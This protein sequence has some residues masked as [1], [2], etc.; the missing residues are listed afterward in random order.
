MYR[1][2]TSHTRTCRSLLHACCSNSWCTADCYKSWPP[3][4]LVLWR[5]IQTTAKDEGA[6]TIGGDRACGPIQEGREQETNGGNRAC[7]P[8]HSWSPPSQSRTCTVAAIRSASKRDATTQ[9][10]RQRKTRALMRCT[11][12]PRTA[13]ERACCMKNPVIDFGARA[14]DMHNT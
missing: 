5:T 1:I 3:S 14:H 7:K 4:T 8:V 10:R 13:Y 6:R 9:H 11:Q 12:V 2:A